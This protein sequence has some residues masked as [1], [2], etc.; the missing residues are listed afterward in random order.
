MAC[1]QST[2]RLDLSVRQAIGAFL[3]AGAYPAE[4][5]RFYRCHPATVYRYRANLDLYGDVA[6]PP[7]RYKLCLERLPTK[8]VRACLIGY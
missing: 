4:L 3:E 6:P 8:R 1:R 7:P 5:A 2:L